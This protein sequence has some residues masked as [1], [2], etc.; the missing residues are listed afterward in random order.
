MKV[1]LDLI[2]LE[3]S[4]LNNHLLLIN[5]RAYFFYEELSNELLDFYFNA[6]YSERTDFNHFHVYFNV[7]EFFSK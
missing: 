5:H 6:I 3:K 1:I 7:G 4:S 2:K